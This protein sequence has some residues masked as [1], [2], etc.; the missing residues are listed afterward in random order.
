MPYSLNNHTI[1]KSKSILFMKK[2]AHLLA[3]ISSTVLLL[4]SCGNDKQKQAGAPG[5]GAPPQV[6]LPL[7]MQL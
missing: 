5:A 4:S 3:A 6:Q 2:A 7:R 1:F